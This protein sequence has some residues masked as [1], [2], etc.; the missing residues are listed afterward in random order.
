MLTVIKGTDPL[1]RHSFLKGKAI[2]SYKLGT[3]EMK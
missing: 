2:E 1:E 3:L